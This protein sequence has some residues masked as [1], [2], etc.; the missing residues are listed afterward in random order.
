MGNSKRA[1]STSYSYLRN[2]LTE[3]VLALTEAH[4]CSCSPVVVSVL[5][6]TDS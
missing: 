1:S 5:C 3:N 2:I 6:M 4:N